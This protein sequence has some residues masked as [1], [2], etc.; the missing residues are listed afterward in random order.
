MFL[1]G[2][3]GLEIIIAMYGLKGELMGSMFGRSYLCDLVP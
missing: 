3:H 1:R 2:V